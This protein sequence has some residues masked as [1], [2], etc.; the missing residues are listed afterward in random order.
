MVHYLK[1]SEEYFSLVKVGIK[2][3]E[4]RLGDR[5]YKIG[6]YLTLQEVD[7][8]GKYTGREI[9]RK[10]DYLMKVE[11]VKRFYREEDVLGFGLVV[12]GLEKREAG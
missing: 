11:T 5:P 2:N 1:L 12:L 10:V 6:D 3:F 7:S 8:Q 9:L 4:I